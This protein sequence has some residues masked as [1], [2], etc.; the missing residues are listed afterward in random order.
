MPGTVSAPVRQD[1]RV[2]PRYIGLF[3]RIFVPNAAV[4]AVACVVLMIQP[5]NGRVPALVGGL[6]VMLVVN[7]LLLRRAFTPLG[8]LT[9]LMRDV[10]PLVPGQRVPVAGPPSEVTVLAQA[11]ADMLDRLEDERSASGRRALSEIEAERRR[12]A[13]EL[14][15][16]LGQSL[17]AIAL[18]LDRLAPRSDPETRREL[19]LIRD[20]VL[21]SVEEVREMAR[22]LRPEALDTLG[23]VPALTSLAER[24]A[25][26]TGLTIRRDL[27]R[28]LPPLT[29]DAELVIFRVAQE[30]LTNVARHARARAVDLSLR[31]DGAQVELLVRDDG[32]GMDGGPGSGTGI[33][34][35][36][37]RAVAVQAALTIAPRADAPGTEVRLLVPGGRP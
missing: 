17:T 10:D 5:A 18:H 21:R 13:G 9:A 26:H 6:T 19:R 3:W 34:S 11:F 25:H 27:Q 29:S 22:R 4:L 8:R 33:R 16:Q 20:D 1:E 15:D 32:D 12:I 7:L 2:T 23:L 35:M 37:E 28:E 14:H 24:L 36:R 30:S 31:A